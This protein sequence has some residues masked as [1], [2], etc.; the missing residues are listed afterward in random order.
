M[1]VDLL[2]SFLL[3]GK[4]A[5]ICGSVTTAISALIAV[6]LDRNSKMITRI[7]GV[8][9]SLTKTGF[10]LLEVYKGKLQKWVS[11]DFVPPKQ[12]PME[13]RITSIFLQTRDAIQRR[14]VEI[15]AMESGF[16]AGGA[17]SS[18]NLGYV[19]AAVMIAATVTSCRFYQYTPQQA[20]KAATSNGR[21]DKDM[22]RDHMTMI[23]KASQR[24]PEDQADA[25]AVAW[26]HW[27]RMDEA[28]LIAESMKRSLP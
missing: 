11:W 25:L 5:L 18:L 24:L 26:C 19:R 2:I 20:K 3:F 12:A 4:L 7:L 9:A 22:V 10:G 23:L 6:N 1:L 21:A 13:D 28:A 17:R 8:D 14:G 16:Y 15:V 27:G